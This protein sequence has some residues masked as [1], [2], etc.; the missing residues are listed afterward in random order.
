MCVR[1]ACTVQLNLTG[2]ACDDHS[3]CTTGD[4]CQSNT[5]CGGTPVCS[6]G[7][8]CTDDA[9]DPATG[10]CL[11]HT[12]KNCDDGNPCT[13]DSCDPAL[14]CAHTLNANP[15]D[16]HN[17]CTAND[18]CSNGSCLGTPAVTCP[19]DGNACTLDECDPATGACV[20]P[21]SF[22]SCNDGNPCTVSDFCQNGSCHSGSPAFCDDSN[23]CTADTC[24][25][26]TG[27]CVHTPANG[28]CNDGNAC[29][30][31]DTCVAGVCRPGA[32]P[33]CDDHNPCTADGCV[34]FAGCYHTLITGPCDD[35]NPCTTGDSCLNGVCTPSAPVSCIDGN[36]CTIDSCDRTTGACIHQSASADCDDGDACTVD[37]CDPDNGTCLGHDPVDCDDHNPCTGDACDSAA[38]CMHEITCPQDVV[39]IL[40]SNGSPLGKGSGT[41]IWRTTAEVSLAGFNVV[42]YDQQGQPARVNLVTIPCT[43]CV[44]GAGAN[45]VYNLPKHKSG[46]NVFVQTVGKDGSILGTFGPAQKGP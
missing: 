1:G 32:P 7:D 43:E 46:H 41:L 22:G 29:T 28:S 33:D 27:A 10:A 19:D 45:Y 8:A 34:S 12:P 21:N 17:A 30:A 26:A 36:A 18:H 4:V 25:P 40:L 14:G 15:C 39:D 24:D 35:G 42:V 16:D 13:A 20:H 3:L 9:C 38:G 37:L 2:Q 31:N 5:T 11:G 23:V 44:T 6:D